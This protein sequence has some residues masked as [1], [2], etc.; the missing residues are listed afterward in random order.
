MLD[1]GFGTLDAATLDMVAATLENLAAARRPHGR[2]G[3]P[4]AGAGR[5]DPGPLRGEQGR[6]G[7]ARLSDRGPGVPSDEIGDG[8]QRCGSL[9]GRVGPVA[10]GTA[11]DR[12]AERGP[13]RGEHAPS[14][15]LD[16]EVPAD[17]VA[18]AGRARPTCAAPSVVLLVDG[19]RRDRRAGLGRG[20]RR[21]AAPGPRRVLR[22]RRG[23]LR[24][25]PGRADVAA[26]RVARGLFTP[27]P[28]TCADLVAAERALRGAPGR[29]RATRPSCR[30][31]SSRT[32]TTLEVERLGR[33]RAATDG[34]GGGRPARRRRAA[35]RPDPAAPGA[36]L[37][38][39]APGAVP[40]AGTGHRGRP[41]AAGP[42]HA[43]SSCSARR[44]TATRGTCKLPGPAGS[45]WAGVV[46]VECSAGPAPR[47]GDPAGRPVRGDAAAV[48]LERRTRT[49]A[50]RRTSPRSPGWSVGCAACSATRGC[51][52]ASLDRG[53]RASAR[54]R[55]A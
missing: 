42:A 5:A 26:A 7:A 12:D 20:G 6:R 45:P 46:R 40:A 52:C 44:G 24:P 14:S 49:P 30:R 31:L 29:P 43:R 28:A 3:H 35:A 13:D 1:E 33:A 18:P 9:C 32:C 37:R 34:D 50:P 38:Q 53:R 51:C 2:R 27:E 23:P 55:R 47:R 54:H 39:D 48:R 19:V 41:A 25:A 16:V 36:R 21:H 4:R 15:T 22:G 11:L 8:D 10:T 17:G